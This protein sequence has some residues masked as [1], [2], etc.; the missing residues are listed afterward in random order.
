MNNNKIISQLAPS[1]LPSTCVLEITYKCNHECIFCSCPW[2][3]PN[4]KLDIK[5][6]LNL[7]DW[8]NIISKL[9]DMGVCS[10][11][12]TGGEPLLRK[13][14]SELI[15]FAAN[16]R[17]KHIETK[18]GNLVTEIKPPKLY[19]L[20]NGKIMNDDILKLCAK[21]NIHLGLS[22]PGLTSFTDH[23]IKSEPQNITKWFKKTKEM[24]ISTHVGITVTKKN[25]HELYETMAES[26][27]AG[28]DSVLLNRFLP[29]GRGLK[30]EKELSLNK[31]EINQM[32]DTAEE[33]LKTANRKGN[34]GTELP[35]CIF[36][37]SKYTNLK[38][39]TQ[40][41]AAVDFFA[42]DPSGFIRV[43]N[44]SEI[45]LNHISDIENLKFNHYWK[46]FALKDYLPKECS[47]C[48]L[49]TSCDGGCREASHICRGNIFSKD[50]IF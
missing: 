31:E 15:A 38:V 22:L 36:E 16:C 34:I 28:A 33:V 46:A 30:H 32:L 13:D 24:K 45:R 37:P 8:Q 7:K 10:I 50:P 21:Y 43:C 48:K 49:I 5:K 17:A 35:K 47:N 41:S 18:N 25:L 44:H 20:S 19:L 14:L 4:K 23:T 3:S 2:F 27:L 9:C 12:L 39:S 1:F 42:I 11:A 6:E 40:C 26:L 29:G